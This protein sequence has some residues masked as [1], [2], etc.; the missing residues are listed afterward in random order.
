MSTGKKN[1]MAFKTALRGYSKESV[2]EYIAAA[3]AERAQ[4]AAELKAEIEQMREIADAAKSEADAAVSRASAAEAERDSA[5]SRV[6]ELEKRLDELTANANEA[7]AEISALKEKLEESQNSENADG[8]RASAVISDAMAVSEN[9]ISSARREAKEIKRQAEVELELA[10][11]AVRKSATDAMRDINK[12]I[13]SAAE[14]VAA[15][16]SAAAHEAEDAAV[17]MNGEVTQRSNRI[18]SKVSHIR[19][20]LDADVEN[21]IAQ[22]SIDEELVAGAADSQKAVEE[23]KSAPAAKAKPSR[24]A[25]RSKS[26]KGFNLASVLGFKK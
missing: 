18:T 6:S 20:V 9:L 23:V 15:E 5:I 24:T 17:R 16:F 13:D 12:M 19:S 8:E 21:R 10:R 2:N 1:A 7:A 3:S 14:Q 22:M 25:T 26:K 4:E 11:D